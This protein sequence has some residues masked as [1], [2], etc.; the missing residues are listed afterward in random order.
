LQVVA[1]SLVALVCD[2]P[3]FLVLESRVVSA[4]KL[5]KYDDLSVAAPPNIRC[6]VV[7]RSCGLILLAG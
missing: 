4:K 3:G 7:D 1:E 2:R 6:A 5:Q